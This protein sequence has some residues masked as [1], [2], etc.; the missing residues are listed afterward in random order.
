[1]KKSSVNTF[2][3]GLVCDLDPINVP[4]NVLTDCL[5][6]TIIT[7]DG[8]EYSLQNDKGNYPLKDCKLNPGFIPVGI[9]EHGGIIYIVS[10]NP[11]TGKEEIGSY[12]SPKLYDGGTND[13]EINAD[14]VIDRT[15]NELQVSE[16]DYSDLES[17]CNTWYYA[18]PKLKMNVGDKF[19]FEED[20]DN[21]NFEK[22]EKFI[23]DENLIPHSISNDWLNKNS[24]YVSPISGR[25]LLKNKIFEIE[26][27]SV[28]TNTFTCWQN[29]DSE[30]EYEILTKENLQNLTGE[31]C[32]TYISSK[33][34]II[35]NP[36]SINEEVAHTEKSNEYSK[37]LLK[38]EKASL[39]GTYSISTLNDSHF[40]QYDSES[41][42]GLM[43]VPQNVSKESERL[44]TLDERSTVIQLRP[45]SNKGVCMSF[46]DNSIYCDRAG[47]G[48]L[49]FIKRR[50]DLHAGYQKVKTELEDW[51][52]KYLL[53]HKDASQTVA[54][55]EP[56][57]FGKLIKE[58]YGNWI[59][60][61]WSEYQIKIIKSGEYYNIK[62][63][64]KY[65]RFD[66]EDTNLV[67][68]NTYIEGGECDWTINLTNGKVKISPSADSTIQ[69]TFP[70]EFDISG[71]AG[72]SDRI[73]LY[74]YTDLKVIGNFDSLFSFT[75]KLYIDDQDTIDWLSSEYL[76]YKVNLKVND[77]LICSYV[78]SGNINESHSGIIDQYEFSIESKSVIDLEWYSNNKILSKYFISI[79]K[80]TDSND[81]IFVEIIPIVSITPDK[82]IILSKFINPLTNT[83]SEYISTTW[84]I[85]KEYYR[86][87]NHPINGEYKSQYIE[88]DIK[89]PVEASD[90]FILTCNI[91]QYQTSSKIM[92]KSFTPGIGKA[93]LQIDYNNNMFVKEDIYIVKYSIMLAGTAVKTITKTL[94]TSELFNYDEFL[95]YKDYSLIPNDV[96]MSKY[97]NTIDW[98]SIRKTNHKFIKNLPNSEYAWINDKEDAYLKNELPAMF[99][100][101][102]DYLEY[103]NEF[104]DGLIEGNEYSF[105]FDLNAPKGL[106]GNL[107][108]HTNSYECVDKLGKSTKISSK[109]F[110]INIPVGICQKLHLT[111]I[112]N[113]VVWGPVESI[114]L[115]TPSEYGTLYIVGSTEPVLN[116]WDEY[117]IPG[118][119]ITVSHNDSV[120][121][122]YTSSWRGGDNI[123]VTSEIKPFFNNLSGINN[124]TEFRFGA[125]GISGLWAEC[126]INWVKI[127]GS[128]KFYLCQSDNGVFGWIPVNDYYAVNADKECKY[129]SGSWYNMLKNN[130]IDFS[131]PNLKINIEFKVFCEKLNSTSTF[132]SSYTWID[133]DLWANNFDID[134]KFDDISSNA[135]KHFAQYN[136]MKDLITVKPE[137]YI[138][139][140]ISDKSYYDRLC[141]HYRIDD[142]IIVSGNANNSLAMDWYQFHE[143]DGEM[144]NYDQP[145]GIIYMKYA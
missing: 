99:I 107:W 87:Y 122:S 80:N 132:N 77:T 59:S 95:T 7:Y 45:E 3:E 32:I 128:K 90:D 15:F 36:T 65:L 2:A 104:N 9:K 94:I 106:T 26:K 38:F 60:N 109:N 143:G 144:S 23:I 91:C 98:G 58:Y 37:Y 139:G 14:Y 129:K 114:D 76:K 73:Y 46:H 102:K 130:L 85:G 138:K 142:K 61:E 115:I 124:V 70:G 113:E 11:L 92:S 54:F 67:F 33:T 82:N 12:P 83:I 51:S 111:P 29:F 71:P 21:V 22:I 105:D 6:G 17:R 97:I 56:Q 19:W 25:I 55:V 16:L 119:T 117:Y 127:T 43:F 68:S 20:I 74:K 42:T 28:E 72:G 78:F 86:F 110:T 8:N 35:A 145:L 31:I 18:D 75:H 89:G 100:Y 135:N 136:S 27:S 79:I 81:Q 101:D 123:D 131:T 64:D 121:G 39:E 57:K 24:E 13:G 47:A 112:S 4:N 126:Y 63:G 5:N 120:L 44:W 108:T 103:I 140:V 134:S 93:I 41:D 34:Y 66:Y 118:P 48:T 53:I 10:M 1:M 52:G 40:L 133:S 50:F 141:E 137:T 30:S 125:N 49:V 69:I 96:W 84:N 88:L 62:R 116:Q